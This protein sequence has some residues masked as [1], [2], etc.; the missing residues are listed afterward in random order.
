MSAEA[1]ADALPAPASREIWLGYI[2]MCIGAFMALLDI[3]IVASSIA[4]IAASMA[5]TLDE[6]SWVQTSYLI[7]EVIMIPL[8]GWLVQ[9]MSMRLVCAWAGLL[10]TI[11]SIGCTLADS[12]G[13]LILCRVVQGFVGGALIPALFGAIYTLFPPRQQQSALVFAGMVATLGPTF[14][15]TIGGWLTQVFSWEAIFLINIGPG[16]LTV[17]LVWRYLPKEKADWTLLRQADAAS[18]LGLMLFLGCG[19]YVLEEGPIQD[20]FDS[21]EIRLLTLTS[22]VAGAVFV[23]R[24]LAQAQPVVDLRVFRHRNFTVGCITSWVFGVGFYGATFLLPLQLV[25]VKGFNSLQ[26]G[27]A[28]AFVGIAQLGSAPIAQRCYPLI[29]GHGMMALGILMAATA[30]WM[31]ARL[32]PGFG[33]GDI[34]LPLLLRGFS[35]LFFFLPI[36]EMTL[37]GLAPA[38]IPQASGLFNLMRNFGGAVGISSLTTIHEMRADLHYLRLRE[39]VATPG[40]GYDAWADTAHGLGGAAD[41]VLLPALLARVAE[42]QASMMAFNDLWLL[43][44]ASLLL[45]ALGLPFMRHHGGTGGPP[46]H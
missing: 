11:A 38:E 8:T 17:W 41:G 43:V 3:Q 35:V 39:S 20:W 25:E 29:G 26:I 30:T 28:L 13:M 1:G 21:S 33:Y 16:A 27:L 37:S 36:S 9:M 2:G 22:L 19:Q 23:A 46:A 31:N 42:A 4:D 7:A 14:G 45:L 5:S 6:A 24:S 44:T 12:L 40:A 10:F 15:P 18:L 32:V 34:A